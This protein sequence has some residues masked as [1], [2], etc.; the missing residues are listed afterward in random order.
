[1]NLKI[2]DR[3]FF[4]MAKPVGS[5]CNLNC[6]YCYYLEKENLYPEGGNYS[7]D[8]FVFPEYKIG[9]IRNSS[10]LSI[11]KSDVQKT[12]GRDKKD[13]LPSYYCGCEFLR[14]CNGEC[15]KNRIIVTPDG[16]HGLNYLC[17]G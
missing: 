17:R 12:F 8:H 15:P 10:I 2:S 11:I 9:N 13:L 4:V 1:M 14:L 16:E 6:S 7:C 3:I 5:L